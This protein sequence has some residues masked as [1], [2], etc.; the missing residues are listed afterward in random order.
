MADDKNM[1]LVIL[2][3]IAVIAVVG[4]VLLFTN[5]GAVGAAGFAREPIG[6]CYRMDTSGQFIQINPI[7]TMEQ[8]ETV[9]QALHRNSPRGITAGG[10]VL[11]DCVL[12]E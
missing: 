4:L 9:Q 12:Y 8:F 2:G 11:G 1:A 5:G 6:E 7:F 3:I 10:T